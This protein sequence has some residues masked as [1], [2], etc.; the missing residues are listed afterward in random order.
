MDD[1]FLRH[2]GTEHGRQHPQGLEIVIERLVLIP[3]TR[4]HPDP[5]QGPL[6]QARRPG[7]LL[8]AETPAR[9]VSDPE[10]LGELLE[11]ISLGPA[12]L[13]DVLS[14]DTSARGEA[15]EAGPFQ[16]ADREPFAI[17]LEEPEA[18]PA[19][20]DLRRTTGGCDKILHGD[21]RPDL[22]P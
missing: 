13:G 20:D 3:Q 4:R 9:T 16:I 21:V 17:A 18:V 6:V 15:D 1:R 12:R 5:A 14:A 7:H 22:S 8:E 11:E 10:Q 19:P 2:A